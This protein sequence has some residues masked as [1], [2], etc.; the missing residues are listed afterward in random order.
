MTSSEDT[1]IGVIIVTYGSADVILDC[2]ES[3]LRSD[4]PALRIVVCDNASPDDTVARL[5]SWAA[6]DLNIAAAAT[7]PL[8]DGAPVAKPVDFAEYAAEGSDEMD[9][10]QFAMVTLLRSEHN[11]GFAGGVN[12]GLRA[13]RPHRQVGLFWLLNPDSVATPGAA[14]A[15]VRAAA[16]AGHFALMGGRILYHEPPNRIQS[17][18]GQVGRWS[19]MCSLINQG[20]LPADAAPPDPDT[21]GFI[22][23][24]NVVA[25]RLFL[26]R[27]GLMCEDYFLYYD[28]VD[29]AFRRGDLPLITC[30]EALIY[31]HGGTAIGTGS[32]S[33]RASAFANYFNYRNRMRFLGRFNWPALPFAYVYALLK[34]AKLVLLGAWGEAAGA[35]RGLHQLPPPATVSARLSPEA[36]ELAFGRRRQT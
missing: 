13:L 6:G 19:G 12:I 26:D 31:H 20:M 2:L 22:S 10:S 11:L 18:G 33:R 8:P 15:Y 30:P 23:G 14:F 28:E 7:S 25:S 35:L 34:V 32:I 4:Y 9:F 16:A 3:L 24:A 21:L 5:R 27:V 29:W 1:T 17:D 36:A